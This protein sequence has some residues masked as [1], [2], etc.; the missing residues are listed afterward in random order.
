VT[1]VSAMF[2]ADILKLLGWSAVGLLILGHLMWLVDRRR[3]ESDFASGYVRGVWDGVW[4]ATVTVTTVGYGDTTPKTA[5]G[6]VIAVLAMVG[7]LFL[8][9]AFVSEVT[10]ALQSERAARVVSDVDDLDDRPVAVVKGS[11]YETFLNERGVVTEG[12][13]T[14]DDVFAAAES[15][16]VD[17]VVAD[18]YSLVALGGEYGLRSTGYLLYDEFIGFGVRDDSPLLS[19]VNA[20]LSDL[21]Q[22]GLVREI[23]DRWTR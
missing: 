15:G 8:V 12:Y 2:S 20:V 18:E 11:S 3:P 19:D 7:S 22:Q 21:H 6:R 23:V 5:P 17:V 10:T 14:Q 1:L 4:W 9:G 13:A 16:A